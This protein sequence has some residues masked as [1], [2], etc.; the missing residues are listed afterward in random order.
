MR[1]YHNLHRKS[2]RI[3][4]YYG[5]NMQCR[6]NGDSWKHIDGNSRDTHPSH[7]AVALSLKLSEI[8]R[9]F[10][11]LC[12]IFLQ[13]PLLGCPV[14]SSLSHFA[15]YLERD[16]C[17]FYTFVV[18]TAQFSFCRLIL[19][20]GRISGWIRARAWAAAPGARRG[21]LSDPIASIQRSISRMRLS[22][23]DSESQASSPRPK[24]SSPTLL[25]KPC[26][27]SC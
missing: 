9:A 22:D 3:S 4:K 15:F 11:T 21:W 26:L 16:C 7:A 17:S 13:L 24:T 1:V 23:S 25:I 5:A 10:T 14:S 18:F 27:I 20:F 6:T 8:W 19:W 2:P 12:V